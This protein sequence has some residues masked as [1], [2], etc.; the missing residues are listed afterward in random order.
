MPVVAPYGSWTSPITPDLLVEQAVGLSQIEVDRGRILWNEARPSEAGRQVLVV[1]GA[2]GVHDLL[3]AP[4]SARTLVHEYGGRCFTSRGGTV[5]FSNLADQRL[6]VLDG[7]AEGADS[8][9]QGIGPRP[10]TAEP[11]EPRAVRFADPVISP[12]GRWLVCVRESHGREV[13]NDVVAVPLPG[14]REPAEPLALVGGHDFFSA[15]RISPDGRRLA[16]LSWDHPDM[17]W[18]HTE[19]WVAPFAGGSLG[20]ARQV[21]GFDGDSVT[22]PR[23]SPDGRLHHVSDRTGWWNLYDEDGRALAPLDAEFS[24]PDWSFGQSTYTFLADGRLV[25]A[26]SAAG[27][28]QLG[29]IEDGSARALD[30]PF[31]SYDWL[32]PLGEGDI[33]AVAGAPILPPAVVQIDIDTR[34]VEVL[35]PSRTVNFDTGFLSVPRHVEFATEGG[36]TA[37]AL[38]YRPANPGFEAPDGERPPLI[39]VS[40]GGPTAAASSELNLRLQYWT[41]R[42]FAVVD[43]DYGGSTGYGREYRERLRDAW[44]IVDVDDCVNAARWLAGR[45]EVDR[46]RMVIRGGSAGGFTTLCALAFRDVFA[47]GASHYGVADLELLARDTHKFEAH[48]LDRLVGPYPEAAE[49]YRRR[50]PIYSVDTIS[51]PVIFFQGLDDPVVPPSQSAL[52]VD[53]MRRRG[54]PVAYLTFE[55]EQ[56]GFR[57]AG[58]IV[59]VAAAELAFYGRVLG[60]VPAGEME[61]IEIS[62]L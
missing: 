24:G 44:G 15:P 51:C 21:A 54:V 58:T 30:L 50:S 32:Q 16:W 31:T 23:W 43:V 40:H 14:T 7:G 13:V 22:Q 47:G 25:A 28:R 61:A 20:P 62:G 12:D 41:S 48:Y 53:A 59:R 35:R 2:A 37:H 8:G 4:H 3:P 6:W 55:G 45:G 33:V 42:G 34:D 56:H 11:A 36:H 29:V 5:V 38:F 18:D 49:E 17:P 9:V 26:W 52:M 10:L 27:V 60:F 57:Q 46:D 1:A 19:L 39:V